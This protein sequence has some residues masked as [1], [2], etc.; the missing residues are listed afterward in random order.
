M[1]GCLRM[2]Y[3]ESNENNQLRQKVLDT[4]NG[5]DRV[6]KVRVGAITQQMMPYGATRKDIYEK[7]N[8]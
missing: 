8:N 2:Q 4:S 5:D 6:L 3:N 1:A 7:Q